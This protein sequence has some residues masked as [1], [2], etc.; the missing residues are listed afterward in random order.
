MLG[1]A[2]TLFAAAS[3]A[4]AAAVP[5]GDDVTPVTELTSAHQYRSGIV[6]GLT[7]GGGIG[8]A[9]GYPNNSSDVG[10]SADYSASCFMAGTYESIFVMGALSD[11]L[12]FG[13]WFGHGIFKNDTFRSNGDGGGLRIEAFPLVGLV[14]RLQGLGLLGQFGVGGGDLQ[15]KPPGLPE[16]SGTESFAGA[17]AFYEWSFGHALG[18]HFGIGP[19]VEYDSIWSHTF[20]RHEAVASLRIVFYGGP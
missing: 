16:A 18:G 11:Y 12:S 5:V 14:P 8:G 19:S 6:L 4:A 3:Q 1:H 20:E 13:F 9:S 15:S 10:N 7:L 17:G 2:L